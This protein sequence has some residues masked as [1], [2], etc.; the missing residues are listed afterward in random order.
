[1]IYLAICFINSTSPFIPRGS[2]ISL[3]SEN[4]IETVHVALEQ[5]LGITARSAAFEL[6][7]LRV[8]NNHATIYLD[9][10]IALSINP[11]DN[12]P[13][14]EFNRGRRKHCTR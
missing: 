14:S 12:I 4:V 1:M 2:K 13:D 10:H 9:A 7:N 6:F 3:R 5:S 8:M 11:E